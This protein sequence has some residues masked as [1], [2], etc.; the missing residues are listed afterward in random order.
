MISAAIIVAA[1]YI[2]QIVT[3]GYTG[4]TNEDIQMVMLSVMI[5]I[6]TANFLSIVVRKGDPNL[7]L[8]LLYAAGLVT[9]YSF[10]AVTRLD[11]VIVRGIKTFYEISYLKDT[12]WGITALIAVISAG[13]LYTIQKY[14]AG[15]IQKTI[16][17]SN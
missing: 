9:L 16:N 13:L 8:F 12:Y 7:R 10:L 5:I 4:Y 11:N 3:E 6:T 17:N 1:S 2:G 15:Y 14:R